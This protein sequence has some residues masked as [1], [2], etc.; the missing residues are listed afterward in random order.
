MNELMENIM[1]QLSKQDFSSDQLSILQNTL[2]IS[3]S[4]YDILRKETLPQI[5]DDRLS[6]EVI[7]YIC[8]KNRCLTKMQVCLVLKI[9]L[10]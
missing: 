10:F 2:C 1:F 7:N 8:R 9:P 4:E 6:I 5:Y 3:M